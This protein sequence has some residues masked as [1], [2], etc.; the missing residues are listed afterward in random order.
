MIRKMDISFGAGC[1]SKS[2]IPIKAAMALQNEPLYKRKTPV[3]NQK[4]P[5][6]CLHLC[7][8]TNNFARIIKQAADFEKLGHLSKLPIQF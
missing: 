4:L 5:F 1:L 2:V 6:F 3:F 8:Q 7:T